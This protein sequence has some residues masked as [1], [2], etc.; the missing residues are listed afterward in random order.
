MRETDIGQLYSFGCGGRDGWVGYKV[1]THTN[2]LITVRD[3][4]S[5]RR[6]RGDMERVVGID[7]LPGNGEA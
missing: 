7:E 5:V 2:Q 4:T 3:M 6:L 1:R